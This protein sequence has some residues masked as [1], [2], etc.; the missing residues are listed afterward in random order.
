MDGKV[1]V[2][3]VQMQMNASKE[4]NLQKA[5]LLI[6]EAAK[7]KADIICLP[8][9]F[10]TLYFPQKEHGKGREFAEK[11]PGKTANK[12]LELS[13]K[14]NVAIVVPFYEKSGSNYYNTIVVV[15]G[16]KLIGKYR[17]IHI[18]H[19]P[20]FYEKNYFDEGN[21]GFKIFKTKK[22]NI[23]T[24]ICFD[25]WYP[26]AARISAINGADIIF[27]PTAIGWI[28]DYKAP[29]NWLDSWITVQRGHSIANGVHVVAVNRVGSEGK[30]DFWGNSFAT[31][32]FGK[33]IKKAGKKEQVIVT[34]LDLS[35]N[36]RIREGWGFIRNRRPKEYKEISDEKNKKKAEMN[37]LSQGY[38]FPAE[39]ETHAA[40][41][42]AWPHDIITFPEIEK[43]ENAIAKMIKALQE[44]KSEKVKLF[45]TG[46]NMHKK[47]EKILLENKVNIKAI[48]FFEHS[49][50]DVWLRDTAPTFITGKGK[51]AIVKWDF[52]SWGNKFKELLKDKNMPN[53][54]N[55]ELKLPIFKINIVGEGGAVETNG[56]GII[57]TTKSCLLNKNRNPDISKEFIDEKLKHFLG[58]EKIIWLESGFP[59]D[60]TDGHS[61]NLARF[62]NEK[63]IV[64]SFESDGNDENYSALK[65]NFEIL[66]KATDSQGKKF[67]IIKL[68]VPRVFDSDG[69]RLAAS[70]TNFYIAN[71]CV[72]M[73]IF[74]IK[75]DEKA[76]KIISVLF[77][78]RKIIKVDCSQ[79]IYGGGTIH[80]ITQQEPKV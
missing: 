45:V 60:H 41:Y 47:A 49:Y 15:E 44:T 29:D 4:K 53:I 55:K 33:I 30:L 59:A 58:A 77:P 5:E 31:D 38:K 42:L 52:N 63:T 34:E 68:P 64:C 48:D 27:Y 8:E 12:M 13:K 66:S 17:K 6:K 36:E 10:N 35:D 46:K 65:K 23:A 9:L 62:T 76:V 21:S 37:P 80:C 79:L 72:L 18:P 50:A 11:I 71:N 61:D 43:A 28:K 56:A 20:L 70:Y 3:I 73:P 54:I 40:V 16:G 7:K 2:G 1:K 57:L 67:R 69:K 51:K 32:A 25:Q 22:A 78:K 74:K 26:E 24:L 19:D 75:S 39:W 14:L